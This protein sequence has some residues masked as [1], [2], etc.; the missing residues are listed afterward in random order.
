MATQT[1]PVFAIQRA[2][3]RAF[4]DFGWLQTHHSFSFA[5]YYDPENLNWGALRVFN[6]DVVQPGKG[7]GTHPHRDM[8]IVTYVLRGE[9]EHRDSMGHHGV[10]APGG[11]QYMSAGT[12]VQHSE[13]NHSQSRDVHFVQMWVLPRSYGEAPAYGQHTFAE[14]ERRNRWLTIASGQSGIEAPVSLR[15]DATVRVARLEDA[16]LEYALDPSRYGFLFVAEGTVTANGETL[17]AGDAVRIHGVRDLAV[18]GSGELVLW[19]VPPTG[20]R[21]EDA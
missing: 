6:D 21:L 8:E 11:V 5:D 7:F 1:A 13:F 15:Q 20:V 3:D 18:R 17:G 12:G 19:D 2:K 16:A 9:L 14:D 10:V 4:F